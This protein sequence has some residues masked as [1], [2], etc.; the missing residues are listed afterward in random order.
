MQAEIGSLPYL[1]YSADCYPTDDHKYKRWDLPLRERI[2]RKNTLIQNDL[3]AFRGSED[4][5]FRPS[6]TKTQRKN[7]EDVLIQM[8]TKA[9][10]KIQFLPS[11]DNS[12]SNCQN[13]TS[14]LQQPN[15]IVQES[16]QAGTYQAMTLTLASG[17][18]IFKSKP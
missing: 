1:T 9:T 11:Y 3:A 8:S 10:E 17:L 12:K 18:L 13:P 5:G 15:T 7:G 16:T 6:G 14:I 2:S 4:L